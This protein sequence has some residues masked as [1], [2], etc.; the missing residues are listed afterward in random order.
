MLQTQQIQQNEFKTYAKSFSAAPVAGGKTINTYEKL[1]TIKIPRKRAPVYLYGFLYLIVAEAQV[2]GE[3][4]GFKIKMTS[5]DEINIVD[6]EWEGAAFS[7]PIATNSQF[8]KFSSGFIPI[9]AKSQGN[10]I[11]V[12]NKSIDISVASAFQTMTADW[13]GYVSAIFGTLSPS[14]LPA[15]YI[16]ELKNGFTSSSQGY[17]RTGED[18]AEA[19]STA[20]S[21]V[22]LSGISLNSKA[23]ELIGVL[24]DQLPNAPTAS[25]ELVGLT[26]FESGSIEDFSPQEYPDVFGYNPTL[27]TVVGGAV[28]SH[29]KYYPVRFP[30]PATEFTMTVKHRNVI[31]LTN[32][33]DVRYGVRYR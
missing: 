27:G 25:E 21:D 30:L 26:S 31:A 15:D 16:D 4:G 13:T 2:A 10:Y 28:G 3:S 22:T 32:A 6:E 19:H 5:A 7:D 11:P 12:N 20:N 29:T 17:G 14:Q 33:P 23:R 18:A 9:T 1:G 24:G 8:V